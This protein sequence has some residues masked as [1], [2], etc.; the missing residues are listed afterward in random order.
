MAAPGTD[1]S[2][3]E[4]TDQSSGAICDPKT[5]AGPSP[6]G[7]ICV[8]KTSTGPS[9]SRAICVPKTSTGPSTC[10]HVHTKTATLPRIWHC[11]AD[12][13]NLPRAEV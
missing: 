4:A 8:P 5:S 3:P 10:R 1:V 2:N 11:R 6:S 7:A 12:L 9:T 13:P